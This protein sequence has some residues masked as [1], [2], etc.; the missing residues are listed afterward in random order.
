[1][2]WFDYKIKSFLETI[3][4]KIISCQCVIK[5][6]SK[7]LGFSCRDIQIETYIYSALTFY[8]R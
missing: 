4:D 7:F 8:Q 2:K 1:M 6:L 3:W 5:M